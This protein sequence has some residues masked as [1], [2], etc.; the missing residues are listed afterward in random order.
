MRCR[1]AGRGVH[2]GDTFPGRRDIGAISQRV[3]EGDTVTYDWA[4]PEDAEDT[5]T[6]FPEDETPYSASA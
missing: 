1:G 2:E 6:F 3:Q 5:V 4:L